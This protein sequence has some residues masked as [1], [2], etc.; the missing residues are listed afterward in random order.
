MFELTNEQRK[1]FALRPVEPHWIRMEPKPSPYHQHTTVTY[2]DGSTL[3]KL[4]QTG[5]NLYTETEICETISEDLKYL[6]PKT[7][8]GKPVLLSAATLEKR[9]PLGMGFSWTRSNQGYTIIDLFSHTSQRN[10]YSN[11][12]EPLY[13]YAEN[14]LDIW[15]QNW[16]DDTT[17]A[18]LQDIA[19]FAALPR[20]RVKFREGDV[21]RFKLSRRLWG[22]GRIVLDYALMRKKKIPFWDILMGKPTACSF[23][24][25]ATQ[26]DDVTV[27]ELQGMKSLP[28]VH[29]MDN[30]LFYGEYEIIGHLPVCDQE[31]YPIMYGSSSRSAHLQRG[32]LFRLLE[33]APALYTNFQNGGIS[34]HPH[35]TLP[36]LQACIAAGSNEPFWNQRWY[37]V[38]KDL[39]DPS[40]RKELEEVCGQ[41]GINPQDL[42]NE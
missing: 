29:L 34:F 6:M 36:V 28:S 11:A 24:H 32:K 18:D 40:C 25:I 4:I 17:E 26:R 1:C 10:Y 8:K 21:F 14:D 39:R 3:V 7:A 2:L 12:H 33:N 5:P 15:V 20:Q 23:Y 19:R 16:C 38:H 22:Y 30:H 13:T 9:T 27:A 37:Q 42:I 41:F 31:D 35:F